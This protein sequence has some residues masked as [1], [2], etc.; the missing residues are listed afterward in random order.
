[1]S[2]FL[3]FNFVLVR[4]PPPIP[5]PPLPASQAA[6]YDN[7][8]HAVYELCLHI[9]IQYHITQYNHSYIVWNGN[10]IKQHSPQAQLGGDRRVRATTTLIHCMSLHIEHNND[11]NVHIYFNMRK[12]ILRTPFTH[13]LYESTHS[14]RQAQLE[15]CRKRSTHTSYEHYPIIAFIQ[16]MNK[17]NLLHRMNTY[18]SMLSYCVWTNQLDLSHPTTVR[19]C[20]V[21]LL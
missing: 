15:V 17:P 3:K 19:V 18:S 12:L 14:S 4:P 13:T 16:C 21:D 20:N 8:R 2:L 11:A 1:M 5:P 9:V 10:D 7:T 6:N